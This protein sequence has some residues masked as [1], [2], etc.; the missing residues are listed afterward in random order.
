[1]TLFIDRLINL[2]KWPMAITSIVCLLPA[3]HCSARVIAL[4]IE[5]AHTLY[6]FIMGLFAYLVFWLLI[7]KHR[8]AGSFLSTLEHECTHAIFALLTLH[9]VTGMRVTW[10]KGGHIKYTGGEGNWLITISPYFV[11]TISIL[12]VLA[13]QLT[14]LQNGPV[15]QCFI[16]A[17]VGFHLGSSYLEL[18]DAQSD[19]AKVG[20]VFSFCFLPTAN[21]L[22]YSLLL[23]FIW[24]GTAGFNSTWDHFWSLSVE[25]FQWGLQRILV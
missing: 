19:L 1:M 8:T 6:A 21:L 24:D 5:S 23:A 18:H 25:A 16:G 2:C 12:A 15:M 9:G 22:I 11:P 17:T 13:S 4:Y 20:Y 3:I 14:S 7:F 10:N